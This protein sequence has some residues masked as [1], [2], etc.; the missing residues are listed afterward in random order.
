MHMGAKKNPD[1]TYTLMG[2]ELAVT[3]QERDLRVTVDSSVKMSAQ[4]KRQIPF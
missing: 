4:W 1:F 2:F 3:N